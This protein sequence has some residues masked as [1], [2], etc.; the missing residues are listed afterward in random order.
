[1][2]NNK[3]Y[4]TKFDDFYNKQ[5]ANNKI[6]ESIICNYKDARL[7]FYFTLSVLVVILVI[8]LVLTIKFPSKFLLLL[9]S[10]VLLVSKI[11]PLYCQNRNNQI[12]LKSLTGFQPVH[13]IMIYM[14]KIHLVLLKYMAKGMIL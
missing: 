5:I 7:K 1:M 4:E 6:L 13:L 14:L 8:L 2:L 12:F 3:E 10:G 9:V 11:Y